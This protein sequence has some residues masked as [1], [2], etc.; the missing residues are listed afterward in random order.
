MCAF[1][2][3]EIAA[4]TSAKKCVWLRYFQGISQNLQKL[5]FKA[6]ASKI[7]KIWRNQFNRNYG[8]VVA[9]DRNLC[10]QYLVYLFVT[11]PDVKLATKFIHR[12]YISLTN[13]PSFQ[14]ALREK[15]LLLR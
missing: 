1:F 2:K 15:M 12:D 14:I 7:V 9:N 13:R 8:F 5:H 11:S 10:A 6:L 3:K 4:R